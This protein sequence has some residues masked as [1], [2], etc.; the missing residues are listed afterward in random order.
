[1]FFVTHFFSIA[2]KLILIS[3]ILLLNVSCLPQKSAFRSV[4]MF[5]TVCTINLFEDSSE[6]NYR[7]IFNFLQTVDDACNSH[8]ESSEISAINRSAG[9]SAVKVSD[10]VIKILGTAIR[11]SEFS[12]GKFDPSIGPVVSLWGINTDHARV[13]SE[14]EIREAVD[15]VD[16]RKIEIDADKKTVFLPQKNM[17]LDL[18]GIAKGFAADGIAEICRKNKI[19]RA[20]I[21]LGGNVYVYGSKKDGSKWRIG[22]KNPQNSEENPLAALT[23]DEGSVVTSGVYERFMEVDGK[24]YHHIFD[25]DT[26]YP[27]ENGLLSVTIICPSSI[28]AD[29]LSTAFFSMG[30]EKSSEILKK[31]S[32]QDDCDG[33]FGAVFVA[34]DRSVYV[35][36]S[37]VQKIT[38]L[39]ENFRLKPLY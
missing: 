21:D 36:K 33:K 14:S 25:P 2:K 32:S 4:S 20:L 13:P 34:A 38:L 6:K 39:D 5:G 3:A 16:F 35:T 1:M 11:I 17:R 30:I 22:I 24:S 31:F 19:R 10:D 9:V 7:E 23:L 29:A 18:G 26:G 28:M 27:V 12:D 15:A 37:M 8:K